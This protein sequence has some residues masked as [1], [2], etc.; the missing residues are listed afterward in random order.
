MEINGKTALVTGGA[1]RVGKAI[2]LGLAQAGANL[3]I[4]YHG[5][6]QAA[7][8]TVAEA[9]SLG[10][11]ALAVQ[12]DVSDP[13][14]VQAMV[15]VAV[16]RFGAVQILVNSAS[17]WR[18]TPFPMVD[19]TDWHRVT[20]VLIDG[21]LFCAN[22]VAPSMLRQGE[23]AIV[24]IVDLAAWEPWIDYTAH[25]VGKAALWALT[26][27]L[28]LELAPGVQVNAV[29]PGPVLPPPDYGPEQVERVARKTLKGRWG[30]AR[31]VVDA[32]LYLCQADYIT[33]EVIA[34][35]GGERWGHRLRRNLVT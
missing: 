30:S 27:Q 21:S 26:Q 3:V 10:V 12:A 35:D 33:G 8:A 28:A 22:A 9:R 1:H 11:E 7:E 17:L 19:Y 20:R 24:N 16:E 15:E 34:V 23:G 18:K 32:V 5:S 31:D 25:S 29:A 2:A 14:Q 13:D 6:A 4:N